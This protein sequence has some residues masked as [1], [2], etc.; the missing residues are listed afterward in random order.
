MAD[1]AG[2]ALERLVRRLTGREAQTGK[3][4][5]A[6]LLQQL[7]AVA[8]VSGREA[9][10]VALG[11]LMQQVGAQRGF[12]A[13]RDETP[14]LVIGERER[15]MGLR[16]IPEAQIRFEDMEVTADAASS[17]AAKARPPSDRSVQAEINP[18]L[19]RMNS[20]LRASASRDG[21]TNSFLGRI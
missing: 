4:D 13:V 5:E 16:A 6:A 8:H 21:G 15:T 9:L 18:R 11:A 14:G 3:P 2:S 20:P 17:N 19:A 1:P 10:D 12:I 7:D